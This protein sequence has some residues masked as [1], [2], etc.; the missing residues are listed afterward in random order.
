MQASLLIRFVCI[1]LAA[2]ARRS[3]DLDLE[4][5][6]GGQIVT[7]KHRQGREAGA[8]DEKQALK[9]KKAKQKRTM[10]QSRKHRPGLG[11]LGPQPGTD[12]LADPPARR[13]GAGR[14]A[15]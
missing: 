2:A 13:R 7:A 1:A 11:P 5:R 4:K 14:S 15:V 10:H 3:S 9:R 8:E 6:P 12:L